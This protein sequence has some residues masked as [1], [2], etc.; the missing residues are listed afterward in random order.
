M[1]LYAIVPVKPL[2]SSKSRLARLLNSSERSELA[3]TMLA[4]VLSA[5]SKADQVESILVV[6]PDKGIRGIAK[7][8]GTLFLHE[9]RPG[10]LNRAVEKATKTC[11]E[12]G[13]RAVL[14]LHADVPLVSEEDLGAL[15]GGT[16]EHQVVIA[17]S[18]DLEGTNALIRV[19]PDVMP[20]AYGPGSFYRH[21]EL[22]LRG[23]LSIMVHFSRSLALDVDRP[24]DLLALAR[25]QVKGKKSVELARRLLR[26]R[27]WL[28]D[29]FYHGP[30]ST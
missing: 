2:S 18:L 12:D 27:G 16:S 10:G 13:A 9:P 23:G 1:K 5:W 26:E 7:D 17:P 21:V 30:R 19:P 4:D 28:E 20:I 15:A 29:E 8:F 24:R 14:V 22:A 3:A 11:I 25:S 6:S